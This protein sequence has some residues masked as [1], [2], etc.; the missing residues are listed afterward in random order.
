MKG[1]SH[2][3]A[4]PETGGDF[5]SLA[6][7][8][9]RR[10]WIV[11]VLA[12]VSVALVLRLIG[13]TERSLW[14]D[15]F[16]SLHHASAGTVAAM[17]EGLRQDNHPPASFLV[18]RW[19]SDLA[20]STELALR[21][22]SLIAGCLTVLLGMLA[23]LRLGGVRAAVA[24]GVVLAGSGLALQTQTEARMYSWLALSVAGMLEALA[25]RASGGSK[26]LPWRT[27]IWVGLGLLTHY[28]FLFHLALTITAVVVVASRPSK[29][30]LASCPAWSWRDTM[31]FLL[32]ALFALPWYA[33][34]F[35]AQLTEHTLA[36]GGVDPTFRDLLQSYL[37]LLFYQL[38]Q[39]PPV[40]VVVLT[41]VASVALLAALLGGLR[42]LRSS[43][44]PRLGVTAALLSNAF[45]I[46][47]LGFGTSMMF[48]RSGFNWTYLAGAVPALAVLIGC[49]LERWSPLR[50]R[51]ATTVLACGLL[52]GG[53]PLLTGPGTEDL[54]GA[55]TFITEHASP[56]DG[57]L[58]VEWQ[59]D[60]FPHG[61]VWTYYGVRATD[62]GP[63]RVEHGDHYEPLAPE[64]GWPA[65]LW[66]LRRGLPLDAPLF[67]ELR[68]VYSAEAGTDFGWGVSVQ[69]FDR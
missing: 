5:A 19:Q 12:L 16:H 56:D 21:L 59:P 7:D 63:L 15:E 27:A 23:A 25:T 41:T 28:W 68:R 29:P 66:V 38:G 45:V 30:P 39:R 69:R 13:A 53:L 58:P 55:A 60:F 6:A 22:P 3:N 8:G 26:Q 57:V 35:L 34:G 46:G 4:G 17:L 42:A 50:F 65:R 18:L 2:L 49:E 64:A 9:G 47:P 61:Q 32:G 1:D 54:R 33:T 51:V 11:A 44:G 37:T 67:V 36:P 52:W 20:A 31:P 40:Q 24:S 10:A 48:Q 14:L 62:D 43:S